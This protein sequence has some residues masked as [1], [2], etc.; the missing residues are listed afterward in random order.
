MSARAGTA[1]TTPTGRRDDNR[2]ETVRGPLGPLT[3]GGSRGH[4]IG[5]VAGENEASTRSVGGAMRLSATVNN[6]PT[7]QPTP[8]G[9]GNGDELP[10]QWVDEVVVSPTLPPSAPVVMGA[11]WGGHI[12][13]P[14]VALSLSIRGSRKSVR[15]AFEHDVQG[16]RSP[17]GSPL[18]AQRHTPPIAHRRQH[19]GLH[20]YDR[21]EEERFAPYL[22][23]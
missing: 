14:A 1:D 13:Q 16:W 3:G 8:A 7:R 6:G 11:R 12:Q 21:C 15:C 10:L 4:P 23:C 9:L 22:S 20:I 17:V 5:A 18:L 2:H 19:G